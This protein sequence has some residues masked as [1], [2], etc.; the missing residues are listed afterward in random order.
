[1]K[2][3]ILMALFS[4]VSLHAQSRISLQPGSSATIYAGDTA[5]VSC[6]SD[7]SGG[8]SNIKTYCK[9][10]K[11]KNTRMN[12]TYHSLQLFEAEI[13]SGRS[14]R[15]IDVIKS[16]REDNGAELCQEMLMEHPACQ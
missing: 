7:T 3:F 8:G 4:S 2:L 12:Y 11:L 15:Q 1:M 5:I 10:L 9:C 6:G 14:S 16:F 13:G